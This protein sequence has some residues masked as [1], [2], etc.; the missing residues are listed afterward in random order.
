[1][2]DNFKHYGRLQHSSN[3]T[4]K[5]AIYCSYSN[6]R[7]ALVPEL[8]YIPPTVWKFCNKSIALLC[9]DWGSGFSHWQQ[10]A[11]IWLW[12]SWNKINSL[13]IWSGV[14]KAHICIN[15]SWIVVSQVCVFQ[16]CAQFKVSYS[17]LMRQWD[18]PG[19]DFLYLL[20]YKTPSHYKN[21]IF[22]RNCTFIIFHIHHVAPAKMCL[23]WACRSLTWLFFSQQRAYLMKIRW[24]LRS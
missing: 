4:V 2:E 21:W 5:A 8:D 19:T 10:Q 24:S 3:Q 14:Q 22:S 23:C 15:F 17:Q 12:C 20:L 6:E 7:M 11:L 1:M 13:S 9:P 18:G 16:T